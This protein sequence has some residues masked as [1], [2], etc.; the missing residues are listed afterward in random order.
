[1]N[2]A[3][4]LKCLPKHDDGDRMNG[5]HELDTQCGTGRE[6]STKK[7]QKDAEPRKTLSRTFP[8]V[9]SGRS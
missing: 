3:I 7:G 8:K 5:G 9:Q 1:M 2:L 4:R 6:N